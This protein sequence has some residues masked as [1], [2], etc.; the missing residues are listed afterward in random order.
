MHL[1]HLSPRNW[2]NYPKNY[3][4]KEMAL[5]A[6]W[7]NQGKSIAVIG[8]PGCGKSNL[9]GFLCY[10]SEVLLS[11][12]PSPSKSI[13]FIPVDLNN[14]VDNSLATFYRVILR[15]FFYVRSYFP[16]KLEKTISTLYSE[17]KAARDPFLTQSAL[18][19]LLLECRKHSLRI[20]LVFDRFDDFCQKASAEMTNTL[21]GF[22]DSFKDTLVY[23]M[24]MRKEALFVGDSSA[25]GELYEIL[26]TRV[27]WVGSMSEEDARN[28]VVREI[29]L[30]KR[31]LSDIDIS[32]LVELS[33]KIPSLVRAATDWRLT[34]IEVPQHREWK[35]ILIDQVSIQYRLI[36]MWEALSQEEQYIFSKLNQSQA[37]STFQKAENSRILERLLAKGICIKTDSGYYEPNSLL[38]TYLETSEI[39]GLGKIWMDKET[40]EIYQGQTLLNALLTPL[41]REVLN[42][43]L[44]K[45]RLGHSKTDIIVNAWPDELRQKGV[46]D[47]SLY[48]I[49]SGIRKKIEPNPSKPL[50]LLNWRGWPESGYQFYPEGCPR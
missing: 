28:I 30:A 2:N 19:D 4:A 46:T 26:D 42:Y 22:R 3:R 23:I 1:D 27:C 10:R 8:L 25:L 36:E 35:G 6:Q 5:L 29:K 12:I 18:Y 33:G 34:A 39:T 47:D 38:S 16:D 32:K 40:G 15:S 44:T 48:Q 21:R 9:L 24:S 43:F 20:V 17:S 31:K 37:E 7:V 11:Y 50:Y 14:L 13:H 41:E 45:P 49:I